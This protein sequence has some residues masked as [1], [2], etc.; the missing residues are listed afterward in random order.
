MEDYEAMEGEYKRML[1][2]IEKQFTQMSE[3][4]EGVKV[5]LDMGASNE[6]ISATIKRALERINK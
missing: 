2:K 1:A 4:I 5:L 6:C 3:L